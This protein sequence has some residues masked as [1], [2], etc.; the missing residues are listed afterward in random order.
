MNTQAKTSITATALLLALFAGLAACTAPGE[1]R[2]DQTIVSAPVDQA[3]KLSKAFRAEAE[4]AV[5]DTQ[6]SVSADLA[7]KPVLETNSGPVTLALNTAG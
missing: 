4:A 1:E 3:W 2:I 7:S 6:I 5:K